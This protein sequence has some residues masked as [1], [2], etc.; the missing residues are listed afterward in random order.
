[1]LVVLGIAAV[2]SAVAVPLLGRTTTDLRLQSDARA[3]HNMVSLAK[4]RA[5]SRYTRERLFFDHGTRTFYL[6]YLD[7]SVSPY[8]WTTEEEVRTL[9]AGIALGYGSVSEAPPNTQ[10]TF[11]QAAPCRTYP[12]NEEIPS[13]SCV[14]FNT[15]G[16]PVYSD[17]SPNGNTG[18]Y[19]TDSTGVY[20]VTV[21]ATPL[22][23]LWWSPASK[24]AWVSR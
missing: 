6:Q 1:M 4:M 9:A 2:A 10:G 19:L 16:I 22:V 20:A 12:A 8:V 18:F 13:T 14:V 23:R 3:L 11:G 17:G 15:R 5:A 7:R 24:T 21:S